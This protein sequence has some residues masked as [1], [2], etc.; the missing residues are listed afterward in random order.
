MCSSR[1]RH[2]H[3]HIALS[4]DNMA[5][6]ERAVPL[7]WIQREWHHRGLAIQTTK[8]CELERKTGWRWIPCGDSTDRGIHFLGRFTTTLILLFWLVAFTWLLSTYYLLGQSI[9]QR[10]LQKKILDLQRKQLSG[11]RRSRRLR[12]QRDHPRFPRGRVCGR[13]LQTTFFY[14]RFLVHELQPW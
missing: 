9:H 14:T 3:M 1:W 8:A 7:L 2:W 4:M 13:N 11:S 12:G 10:K 6:I 5:S